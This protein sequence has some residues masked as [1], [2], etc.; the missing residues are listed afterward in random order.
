MNRK[1]LLAVST[2]ILLTTLCPLVFAAQSSSIGVKA[3]DYAIYTLGTSWQSN[4]STVL[5]SN[6]L[7]DSENCT[8]IKYE[9]LNV[10]GQTIRYTV[11]RFFNDST[12]QS[13]TYTGNSKLLGIAIMPNQTVLDVFTIP[14]NATILHNDT[15][16]RTYGSGGTQR[17]VNRLEYTQS[18][19]A[20][21][22]LV[23]STFWDNQTG[24]K[25]E[26]YQNYTSTFGNTTF[27]WG[28]SQVISDT[29]LFQIATANNGFTLPPFALAI[30]AG[31]AVIVSVGTV[32]VFYLRKHKRKPEHDESALQE[33]PNPYQTPVD[34]YTPPPYYYEHP[35]YKKP[36]GTSLY[37]PLKG[38]PRFSSYNASLY[39][40]PP[41]SYV[42]PGTSSRRCPN[43]K[44]I[45]SAS[46]TYCSNCNKRLW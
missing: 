14:S 18:I 12:S 13:L 19:D 16:T 22:K 9:I 4:Q 24:L 35:Y 3:G 21:T 33:M 44:Q 38:Q 27:H 26:S 5:I 1:G 11:T 15:L 34:Y 39:Q 25:M 8:S 29:N 42:R 36:Y 37:K 30:I 23:S 20:T 45:V 43:C 40:K 6:A 28:F 32:A 2:I 10:T 31:V 46:E 17:I 41:T 7:L